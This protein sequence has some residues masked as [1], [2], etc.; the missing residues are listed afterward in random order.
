[1]RTLGLLACALA[2]GGCSS[3]IFP[4]SEPSAFYR[5]ET[6]SSVQTDAPW[7]EPLPIMVSRPDAPRALAS[8]NIA[9]HQ[10]DGTL[11]YAS[12]VR[13][14]ESMPGLVQNSVIEAFQDSGAFVG[15]RPRDGISSDYDL[16]LEIH[17]FE[18]DYRNGAEAAPVADISMTA[19]LLKSH[20]RKVIASRKFEAEEAA[21]DNRVGK[22]VTGF[23]AAMT[24]INADLVTW[25]TQEIVAFGLEDQASPSEA[26]ASR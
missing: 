19:R 11:A 25:T 4:K 18:A 13:W 3:L 21:S 10:A 8:D 1:M 2:L 7:A 26:E 16:V 24:R 14:L 12:G 5:L 23:N 9:I 15:A 22:I 6:G 17:R 20:G